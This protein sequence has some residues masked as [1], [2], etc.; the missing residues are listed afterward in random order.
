ME[1]H[2]TGETT[3]LLEFLEW[4]DANRGFWYTDRQDG[5]GPWKRT[6]PK[7][8]LHSFLET[9]PAAKSAPRAEP[10]EGIKS[11]RVDITPEQKAKLAPL[12]KRV[13]KEYNKHGGKS[14]TGGMIIAQVFEDAIFA[15]HITLEQSEV[16]L[17]LMNKAK[18]E[19]T[20]K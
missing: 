18:K 5:R 13:R 20:K 7:E 19:K 2:D 14:R 16:F 10:L 9:R 12:F 15:G 6:T 4:V 3:I 1:Q 11:M 17:R 8:L